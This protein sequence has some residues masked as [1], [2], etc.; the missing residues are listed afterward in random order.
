MRQEV[1]DTQISRVNS[2]L[3]GYQMK[4]QTHFSIFKISKHRIDRVIS[5][6]HCVSLNSRVTEFK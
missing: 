5:L 3:Y 4:T 6:L 2:S 1:V